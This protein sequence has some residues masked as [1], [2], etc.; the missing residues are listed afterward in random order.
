MGTQMT[1]TVY[2]A[3]KLV[4]QRSATCQHCGAFNIIL[5]FR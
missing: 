5:G 3:G 1:V 2:I 4:G